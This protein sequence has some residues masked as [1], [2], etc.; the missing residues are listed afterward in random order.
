MYHYGKTIKVKLDE[1]W[2]SYGVEVGDKD[3]EISPM[4]LIQVN[5]VESP[6]E[7]PK[8][9]ASEAEDDTWMAGCVLSIYRL[10]RTSISEYKNQMAKRITTQLRALRSTAP[11]MTDVVDLYSSWSS[12]KGYNIL[13]ASFD[14]FFHRFPNHQYSNLRI[15]TIGSRYRDCAALLSFGY[16]STLLGMDR[17]TEVMDWVFVEQVGKD[18]DRM[19]MSTDERL[20]QFSYFPYHVDM[21]LVMKS[22][23]STS[24]NPHF[25]EW[26]HT[27]GTLLK[28]SR[29]MNAA[30]VCEA[31]LPDIISN[32]ACVAFAFSNNV[33]FVK[34]YT[35]T[36]APLQAAKEDEEEATGGESNALEDVLKTR[37]P[38]DWC[39]MLQGM[40]GDIPAPVKN[41]IKKIITGFTDPRSGTIAASLVNL[42]PTLY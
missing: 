32:A 18:I 5:L 12:D 29:S 23:Y 31:R 24:A 11:E 35:E 1:K 36:G 20:N 3:Q 4:S 25:F 27:I 28:S 30:H 13:V 16:I 39:S 14:M 40:E 19:M 33:S 37:D 21:G 9:E 22:A 8:S 10:I 26:V 41:Y 6:R 2:T 17:L 38:K 34:V 42:A 7:F 15:G